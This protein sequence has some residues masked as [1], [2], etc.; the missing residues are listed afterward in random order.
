MKAQ[1]LPSVG[2]NCWTVMETLVSD[3]VVSTRAPCA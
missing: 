1:A 2:C 3:S